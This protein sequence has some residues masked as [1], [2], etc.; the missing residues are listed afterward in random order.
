MLASSLIIQ[1]ATAE[2]QRNFEEAL[3]NISV[4]FMPKIENEDF[5]KE[6]KRKEKEKIELRSIDILRNIN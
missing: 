3:L 4:F 1:H 2:V 6:G 5:K